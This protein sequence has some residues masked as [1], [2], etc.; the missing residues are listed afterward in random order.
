[1][2]RLGICGVGVV[3]GW[4]LTALA[5]PDPTLKEKEREQLRRALT[6]VIETST[7]KGAR[8][9]V[10]V[11]SLDDGAFVYSRDGD[12]LL[13]PASNVKLFTAATAL[14]A[15]GPDFRFETDFLTDH[16]FKEGKAKV[17]YVRGRGDPTI[18]TERLYGITADL[19]HAGLKEITDGIVLDESYFDGERTAPGFDQET[20]DKSY[21]APTGALSLN[22]NS[23]GVYLRPGDKVGQPAATEVEP[24]SDFFVIESEAVTGTK[25]QR[26]YTVSSSVDKDKVRQKIEVKGVVPIDKGVW[27]QWKKI[28]QPALYFGFTLKQM[29]QARGVK[30]KGR[31]RAGG[32]PTTAK[33][34][35]AS[36]SDTLDIVLKRLNKN[37]SN[38]VAEQLIKVIGAEVKGVPGS[39]VKGIEAVED[40]LERDVGIARGTF[41]MKNGSGLND[42]NRFSAAQTNQVLA[43]MIQRFPI[44]PEY[45]SALAIAAKDGTLKY[46]FEGSEAVGRLR[47]KTG[48]L[49]N[50]SALSGY[51]QAVGGERFVFSIMVNDFPG[52]ASSVVQH[53]D[54]LGAA[55]ASLGSAQGPS[56]AVASIM[57][58]P[59]VV[60]S[61]AELETRL[62][63]YVAMGQ[64]A[65][66][67]NA[68]F[69]RTAWRSEKDPAVRAVIA[70]ALILSDPKEPANVRIF[71]DS[72]VASGEVFGRLRDAS[73]RAQ[74]D[75]PV[76]PSLVELAASGHLEAVSRLFEFVRFNASDELSAAFLA[77]QLA[78]VAH[79]A[80]MELLSALRSA[81][82]VD[83]A[84]AL[85]ALVTGLVKQSQA[86]APLWSALKTAQ[87][88]VEPAMAA[89]A[90]ELEVQLSQR[91]A[92][93][94]APKSPAEPV[95][96][97]TP[98]EPPAQPT[99][100]GG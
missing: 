50:V 17:L 35:T 4:A 86:D 37:S 44:A 8:V 27:S 71:L 95:V 80:P 5:A 68:P 2:R 3:L 62:K 61:A 1:M 7:L 52:R 87:G 12:E 45:L 20:G 93:A 22:W 47:A 100:P 85:D 18:T 88:S 99:A 16:D 10:Q 59:S 96:V 89:F 40:F 97:P 78:V 30:V 60:T 34:L 42:S 31:I 26:R 66:R 55:V 48:T 39:H 54:A 74:L 13:N 11:K 28:D 69:L 51:V 6:S 92:E 81:S 23:V 15:L 72:A 83:R 49:E 67:R 24:P 38:F 56:A 94:K 43:H 64:R 14:T 84:A 70:D 21:L 82:D 91:I 19:V 33:L 77:E 57:R 53:I 25:T 90:K 41:V 75:V 36:A 76:L 98:A 65:D 58:P 73:K 9:T 63:T 32:V 46:R 29:L 79:D